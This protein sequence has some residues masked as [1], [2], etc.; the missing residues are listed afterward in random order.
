MNQETD[1]NKLSDQIKAR[2]ISPEQWHTLA[3]SLYPGAKNASILLVI[4]YCHARKLD[5]LKRPCHIVPMKVGDDWRDVIL[6][7]IYE[8]RTT[9]QRTG[10]YLGHSVPDYGEFVEFH[11]VSAPEW[12]DFTVYRWNDGAQQRA[13]YPVRTYFR[14]VCAVR[15]DRDKGEE[16]VNAR[17]TRAPVQMLTKC[18]E[19]AALRE[20]FPD[21]LGGEMTADEMRGQPAIEGE[22]E[23]A[24]TR[25]V[26]PVKLR[27]VV[28][29][30][31]DV[32]ARED[33]FDLEELRDEWGD[34]Q[35]AYIVRTLQSW[36]RT[37][38]RA[39][40]DAAAALTDPKLLEPTEAPLSEKDQR[41]ADVR[42]EKTEQQP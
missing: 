1:S 20:A 38:L 7:G 5:P 10:Q 17:W 11:G 21:E 31:R 37:A 15:W 36:E 13:E 8:Y 12:C 23:E 29:A 6:P 25:R 16:V 14:E 41:R 19:A 35:W 32:I 22:V 26:G 42:A 33:A 4:D 2:G 39:L 28:E 30:I 18:A 9:A 24:E 27:K 34:D 3:G 40:E